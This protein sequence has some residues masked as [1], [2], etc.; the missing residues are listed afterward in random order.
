MLFPCVPC[1]PWFTSCFVL[2]GCFIIT[3]APHYFTVLSSK[4]VQR[5]IVLDVFRNQRAVLRRYGAEVAGG[6]D[7]V[8]G[9]V[10]EVLALDDVAY[11]V[12]GDVGLE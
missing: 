9:Q 7:R 6:K 1:I 2:Y 10:G 11:L 8:G 12:A 5:N 3:D 4:L